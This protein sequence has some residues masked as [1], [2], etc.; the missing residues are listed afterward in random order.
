MLIQRYLHS[1]TRLLFL[2]L[3]LPNAAAGDDPLATVRAFCAADGT[4]ARLTRSKWN[5]VATLVAWQLEPAWDHIV[6]I[7]GYEI[8]TP[9]RSGERIVVDVTYTVSADVTPGHIKRTKRS[10]TL[11]LE[12]ETDD[13]GAWRIAGTPPLPH[14]FENFADGNALAELLR[15]DDERYTSNSALAWQANRAEGFDHPYVTTSQLPDS[16][17]FEE[18]ASASV[19]DLVMYY[20]RNG[21]PYHVAV[22]ESPDSI[23]TATLNAGTQVAP[24]SAFAGSIR[25]LRQRHPQI[26]P[27]YQSSDNGTD[28][29]DLESASQATVDTGNP[30]RRRR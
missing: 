20:T 8:K 27:G 30:P 11:S 25:Y 24:F 21:L 26:Q 12:I 13:S 18:V 9:R 16:Q 10:E 19:G 28:N 7:R 29:S 22:V 3:L 1:V 15:S 5:D 2:A 4:G 6:L 14:V 23:L 17:S